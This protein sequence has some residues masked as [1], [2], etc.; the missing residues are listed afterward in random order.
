M[1]LPGTNHWTPG[2]GDPTPVGWFTVFAYLAVAALC[3]WNARRAQSQPT[4]RG[5]WMFLSGLLVL[6]AINKQLDLQSWFTMVG[7]DMARAQ[8]WYGQRIPVQIAFITSLVLASVGLVVLLRY[9]LRDSW[10]RYG[11]VLTGFAM[12]LAFIVIRATTMHHVDRLLG[13]DLGLV[14]INN[15]LELGSLAVVCAGAWF[16]RPPQS[17]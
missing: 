16:W 8:G 15:V 2:I 5:T 1:I 12:L 4:E 13:I 11:M 10:Q 6:L 14:R 17:G 3:G 7:R 9:L